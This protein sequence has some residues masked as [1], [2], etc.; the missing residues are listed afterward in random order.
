MPHTSSNVS[1]RANQPLV[2]ASSSAYRSQLLER[3]RI[4]FETIRPDVDETPLPDE[5]PTT[6]AQ[7]LALAKAR[8]GVLS[9]PDALVIGSDQIATLDGVQIGK[10]GTPQAAL[11]QL[12]L[13]RGREVWFH[14]AL[15]LLD[16]QSKRIWEDMASVRVRFRD[17]P[18]AEIASYL[19]ADQPWDVAGSARSE[20]L[21][22]V[23]LESI[24]SDDPTALVGLPL[25]RL[26]N[27][28]RA[29]GVAMFS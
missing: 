16:G 3:L 14:S 2:L 12:Q 8:V 25:I 1:T 19:K 27:M 9:H 28:L 11:K 20:G 22:I 21:G 18:D 10:P 4:P 6:T 5:M 26:T 17:L 7:R 23:L 24:D 29:A 15:C 13:M